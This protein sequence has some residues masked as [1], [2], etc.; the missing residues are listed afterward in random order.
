MLVGSALEVKQHWVALE[1][2]LRVCSVSAVSDDVQ[3]RL[4]I[5]VF[6]SKPNRDVLLYEHSEQ[7]GLRFELSDKINNAFRLGLWQ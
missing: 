1:E 7:F 6:D 5:S 3:D 2:G 4:T